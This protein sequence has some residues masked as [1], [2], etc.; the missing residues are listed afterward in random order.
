MSSSTPARPLRIVLVPGFWCGAWAWDRVT[1]ALRAAGHDVRA[2]TL[3]GLAGAAEDRS[4]VTLEDHVAAV[5]AALE[6]EPDRPA[7]LVGHSGAGPVVTMAADRVPHLVHR[8]VYVDS[9]P[10]P[11]GMPVMGHLPPGTVEVPLPSEEE[12]EAGGNSLEGLGPEDLAEFRERAVPQPGGP[13]TGPARLPAGAW[14]SVPATVVA[15]SLRPAQIEEFIAAGVPYFTALGEMDVTMV[16]LPTGHWPMWSRPGD[17]A[18]A[19]LQA[20]R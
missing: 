18:A 7:L 17:L 11:D 6:E 5:A 16:D 14:R 8:L 19:L 15:C 1:P 10:L 20:A 9:G 4:A 13:A 3:P 2:L 12:L